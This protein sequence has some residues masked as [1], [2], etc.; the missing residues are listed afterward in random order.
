MIM[1]EVICCF[2]RTGAWFATEHFGVEPD[3]MTMAK[4]LTAGYAPM[5]AT[6]TT[7]AIADAI[8]HFRHVLTYRFLAVW[9]GWLPRQAGS[10]RSSLPASR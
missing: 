8:S 10:R 9:G 6:V 5:G 2:G 4:A 3:I 7:P 1:D